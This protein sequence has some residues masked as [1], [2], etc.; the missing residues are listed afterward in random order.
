M[1]MFANVNTYFDMQVIFNSS[2]I[3]VIFIQTLLAAEKQSSVVRSQ[4]K[5][6]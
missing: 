2:S 5:P 3:I 4:W 1:S 6:K